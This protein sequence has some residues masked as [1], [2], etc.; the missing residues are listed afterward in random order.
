[1][2]SA[3]Y[4]G[5]NRHQG[6]APIRLNSEFG[7][8]AMG[9]SATRKVRLNVRGIES[10]AL[11]VKGAVTGTVTLRLHPMLSDAGDDDTQGTRATTGGPTDVT[12]SDATEAL[13]EYTVK[14]EEY[15]EVEIETGGTGDFTLTYMDAFVLPTQ[16]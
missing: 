1:M 11:R 2:A 12:L 16:I 6:V 7:T 13:I 4:L 14:G 9:A 5:G 8:T 15:V 3:T 10:L